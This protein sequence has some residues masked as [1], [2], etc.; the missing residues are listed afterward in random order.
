MKHATI[1]NNMHE[2]L[3][4]TRPFPEKT[5]PPVGKAI[6][7][8]R[9]PQRLRDAYDMNAVDMSDEMRKALETHAKLMGWM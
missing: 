7:T 6:M 9:V 3:F 2:K 5:K 8:A 1:F 4:G